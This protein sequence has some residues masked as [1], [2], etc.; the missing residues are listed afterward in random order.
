MTLP[1]EKLADALERLAMAERNG[2]VRHDSLSNPDRVRLV[3]TGFLRGIIRGWYHLAD[4]GARPGDT[5]WFSFYWEFVRQYLESRFGDDYCLGAE[6]SLI[7]HGRIT[8]LPIQLTAMT[9][10][11][12]TMVQP[13]PGGLSLAI[14]REE[15]AFPDVRQQ[16]NGLQVFRLPEA[17]VRVQNG[18]FRNQPE[19]ASVA[20]KLVQD[21][22]PL[23]SILLEGGRSTVAGRLAGAFRANHQP[24]MASEI[25]R[26]MRLA[27]FDVRETNPFDRELPSIQPGRNPS[28]YELRIRT[29][30]T[31]FREVVVDVLPSPT[32]LPADP[33]AFMQNVEDQYSADAYHSLS[34]EGYRVT[35]SLVERVRSGEWN[36]QLNNEDRQSRDALA[37]RGYFEAFQAVKATVSQL[38]RGQPVGLVRSA[39]RDWYRSLFLSSVDAGILQPLNLA[40][41]RNHPVFISGSR[42]VPLPPEALMDAMTTLFDL[43]EEEPEASVRAVLGHFI[44]VFI[45][46]YGD[47]NGRLGRFLMNAMLA[48]GGYP[49]TVIRV[50]NRARYMAA[51]ESASSGEDIRPLAEF[52]ASEMANR[53][54][55]H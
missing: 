28:P 47:G 10:S 50:E 26:T 27:A 36:P 22:S 44:F 19:E 29:M 46:P 55:H 4:P 52:I 42:H 2:I 37:A 20:L 1:H 17:L 53:S 12:G 34:I 49:W 35:N 33:N 43:L 9:K 7:L 32:G 51:L 13:L 14:Y 54:F 48:S 5:E 30:W 6:S 23:L 31:R 16:I 15:R 8:T 11:S 38:V 41:Y 18:F 40:G 24:E 3:R 21:V 25:V 39:H 45:H